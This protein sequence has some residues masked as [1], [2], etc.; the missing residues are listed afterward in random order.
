VEDVVVSVPM[1]PPEIV[2]SSAANVVDASDRVNVIV[3]VWPDFRDPDPA[4]V[5]VTVGAVVSTVMFKA[6]DEVSVNVSSSRY[7]VLEALTA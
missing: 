3:S 2:M 7:V 6:V 5:M 4:R 1:L